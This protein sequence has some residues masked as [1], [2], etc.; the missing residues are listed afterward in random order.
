MYTGTH[1]VLLNVLAS[2]VPVVRASPFKKWAAL[3]YHR[4]VRAN[5]VTQRWRRL[6]ACAV[7]ACGVTHRV[8]QEKL[9]II[10]CW[11]L[12]ST[13]TSFCLSSFLKI[14]PAIRLGIAGFLRTLSDCHTLLSRTS[15][16]LVVYQAWG[17]NSEDKERD[18]LPP[19]CCAQAGSHV[20]GRTACQIFRSLASQMLKQPL[21]IIKS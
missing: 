10:E 17:R 9:S 3:H 15:V 11:R 14:S 2:P 16:C 19:K 5:P 7:T 6:L 20:L 4:G 12:G 8:G 21:L 13:P 1:W 18:M